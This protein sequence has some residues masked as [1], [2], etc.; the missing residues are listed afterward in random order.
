MLYSVKLHG[1]PISVFQL[2]L[3][4]KGLIQMHRQSFVI[5]DSEHPWEFLR[6]ELPNRIVAMLNPECVIGKEVMWQ[7]DHGGKR[8]VTVKARELEAIWGDL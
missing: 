3:G 6:K 4:D 8:H 7:M 1:E 2:E 5:F